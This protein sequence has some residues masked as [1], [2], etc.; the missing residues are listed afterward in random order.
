MLAK[1]G[2]LDGKRREPLHRGAHVQHVGGDRRA[3]QSAPAL[4]AT[5]DIPR[6]ALAGLSVT[7]WSFH[8][9]GN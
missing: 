2:E 6:Q 8:V 4:T 5:T 3:S 1:L 9:L 7:Q